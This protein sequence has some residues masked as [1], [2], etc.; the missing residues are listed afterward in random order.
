MTAPPLLISICVC[1][2]HRPRLLANLLSS[3]ANQRTDNKF[4]IEVVVV[5]NDYAASARNMVNKA[6]NQFPQLH[7]NY[8][9][10]P[11]QGLSH[12]RNRAVALASGNYVAFIDDDEYAES[13]WLASL[14]E[15]LQHHAADAVLGPVLPQFPANAPAWA[16]KSK[17]FERPRYPTGTRISS[18]NGRTGNALVSANWLR[19]RK[20]APFDVHFAH[21]G[22]EDQDFFV[23][24]ERGGATLLWCDSAVVH[25]IVP[26]AR[27]TIR[28]LLMRRFRSAVIYSRLA[29]QKNT[30]W[31]WLLVALY[32]SLGGTLLF[33]LGSL[34][35]PL[36]L[37]R[38]VRVW[39]KGAN[40][41]GR[42]VSLSNIRLVAYGERNG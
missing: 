39:V 18:G 19:R 15:T 3:L 34:I 36:G 28:Y 17:L 6:A 12:A 40:A 1:T 38:A 24:M 27:L 29:G 16:K 2:Y 35:L 10:E 4:E 11:V 32:G 13:D 23:W 25:E 5:D 22:A 37:H 20:P 26:P 8:E 9:I 14:L 33:L 7:M 42:L 30:R 21:S 41:Y 31:R